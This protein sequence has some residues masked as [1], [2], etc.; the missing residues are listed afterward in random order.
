MTWIFENILREHFRGMFMEWTSKFDLHS[1]STHS[2][3]EHSTEQVASMM[4]ANG[5]QFWSLTDHDTISGWQ[6]AHR[7]AIQY[8][9]TFIPGIEITCN[10]GIEANEEELLLRGKDRASSSWHLLAY[11]PQ[12]ILED[13]ERLDELQKWLLP[14]QTGRL[15]RMVLMLERLEDLGMPIQLEAVTKR[16]E[17]SLGRPHLAQAMVDA[18]YVSTSREAFDKY[19]GD[20]GIAFVEREEPPLFDAISLVHRL[21]GITSLAHPL[22]YGVAVDELIDYLSNVECDAVEVFHRSHDDEYRFELL[23]AARNAKLGVTVG[24]DFHGQGHGHLPGN[25]VVTKA[26]M[27]YF[28]QE[29]ETMIP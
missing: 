29:L 26:F 5:V 25:M 11:F 17:G 18:G 13:H 4:K 21:G 12:S 3:G 27:P 22:Y 2:D 9:L 15:P 16:A 7:Y 8:G 1:H 19:I 6:D 28:F 24:S 14:L 10:V 23:S 20:G